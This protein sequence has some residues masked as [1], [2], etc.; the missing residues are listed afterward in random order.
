MPV[1]N[2]VANP[3]LPPASAIVA[4]KAFL[5]PRRRLRGAAAASAPPRYRI[6]RTIEVDPRDAP[7]AK[8]AVPAIGAPAGPPGDDF[9]GKSRRASK[10]SISSA[11]VESF[12]DLKDLV[13]TL[14]ADAA[15]AGRT[16]PIST[17]PTSRRV[18]EE[19]RNVAVRAFLYAASREDDND[20]HLIL[21]RAPGAAPALYMTV[22]LSGLPAAGSAHRARLRRA[23][24]AYKAFFGADL[25]GAS[26]DFYVPPIPVLVEGSLFFDASHAEGLKPGPASLRKKI[27]TVW[28]IHPISRI[29]FEP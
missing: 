29:A 7:V 3:A 26:Y 14:P 23:R 12:A 11:A 19:R 16:P 15:M 13:A 5:P 20:Y 25:P 17:A 10:L 8:R 6:L 28:E 1:R 22:E 27:P 9:K 2:R 21:G 4:E 18:A 24:D